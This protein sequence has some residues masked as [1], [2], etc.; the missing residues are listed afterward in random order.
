MN[1]QRNLTR[2]GEGLAT[3]MERLSSGMRI[4]SAKDDA[5]GLQIASRLTSQING[6]GVA[7]RNANDGISMAQTAEGAMQAST[8]ILQRMRELAL[9]SANGSNSDDDRAALQKEVSAL[10]TELTR[11]ADT[12][13]FGGQQLLDGTF[14]SKGFQVGANSGETI[15]MS[16]GDVSADVLGSTE[17]STASGAFTA[18]EIANILAEDATTGNSGSL[19]FT[20]TPV[21]AAAREIEIDLS[22]VTDEESFSSALNAALGGIGI[23]ATESGGTVTLT[24]DVIRGEGLASA[25]ATGA[26]PPVAIA[27]LATPVSVTT[28]ADVT[29]QADDIDISTA[30]GSGNALVIIDNA[31]NE[32]NDSRAS[33]GAVQNRFSHTINNLANIQENVSASRSRIEDTDFAVETAMMTKNQI[34]Q[35][36]GTSILAQ[37][38]QIPQ[39]AI[40]LIGG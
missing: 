19:T 4:N 9:Q 10:Q 8:D 36:A 31:L 30:F 39:A 14:G 38:N 32:I 34:L 20:H 7:Q 3:S 13:S 28:A 17:R 16:L 6:L 35:Q 23:I 26:N 40:S 21:D 12:T 29:V 25:A 24:G 11:I 1:A 27:A 5:A 2:S 15:T 33:L 18:T 22:N 37:A